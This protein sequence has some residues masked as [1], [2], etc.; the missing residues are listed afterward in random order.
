MSAETLSTLHPLLFLLIMATLPAI[1][2]PMTPFYVVAGI[3]YGVPLGLLLSVTATLFNLLLCFWIARGPLRPHLQ[4]RLVR[5][6][7]LLATVETQ[8]NDA[9]RL[10][11]MVKLVPG[12]P[13]FLKHYALGVVG[14]PLTVYLGAALLTTGP[15]SVAFVTLGESALEGDSGQALMAASLLLLALLATTFWR[16]NRAQ[17]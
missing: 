7:P 2:L 3:G 13:M 4:A 16:R 6:M 15:Y 10:A 9:W 1:G 17:R 12:V 8:R 11:M 14:V 5:R